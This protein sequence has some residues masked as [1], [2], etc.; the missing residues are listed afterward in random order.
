MVG[1]IYIARE[2][3]RRIGEKMIV[4]GRLAWGRE[5]Y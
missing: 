3:E 2:E 4:R 5:S 1:V